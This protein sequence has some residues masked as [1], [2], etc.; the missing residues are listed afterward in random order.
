M[1][2]GL[3]KGLLIGTGLGFGLAALAWLYYKIE[4]LKIISY[5]GNRAVIKYKAAFKSGQ[6]TFDFMNGQP[7][8]YLITAGPPQYEISVTP[9]DERAWFVA[10]QKDGVVLKSLTLNPSLI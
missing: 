9:Q 3:K 6:T 1:N 7:S 4:T 5:D 10:L 8:G 2:P